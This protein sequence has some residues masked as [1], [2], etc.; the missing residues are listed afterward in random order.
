MKMDQRETPGSGPPP[1]PN[2][3]GPRQSRPPALVRWVPG[4]AVF[5][6]YRREWLHA[7]LVAGVSVCV[8]MIPSVI[9]SVR[10]RKEVLRRCSPRR[11]KVVHP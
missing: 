7:D 10:N 4:L 11:T 1:S 6:D 5:R 2:D 8:V 3:E 9:A